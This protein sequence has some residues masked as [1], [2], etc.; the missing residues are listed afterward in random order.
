MSRPRGPAPA[1]LVAVA[2]VPAAPADGTAS[3][4]RSVVRDAVV[5][6]VLDA[7]VHTSTPGRYTGAQVL[8]RLAGRPRTVLD[9]A[10]PLVR[11]D[12]ERV[13]AE[14]PASVLDVSAPAGPAP[15]P[16]PSIAVVVPTVVGRVDELD[17]LLTSLAVL[18][19]PDVDVVLVDNRTTR[20]LHDPLPDLLARHPGVRCVRE[21]RPGIS[22]ARNAGA[23]AT[24]A[25]VVA[26][27][28]DD[29]AVDPGWLSALADRF[30]RFPDELAVTGLVVP[31]ELETTAQLQYEAH[32]GGFGGTRTFEA[33]RISGSNRRG[34]AV[35]R[36]DDDRPPH[37]LPVYGVGAYG[38]GANMAFRRRELLARGG[39]DTSLGTGT[40]AC[41]GE[42]LAALVDVLWSGG[43]IGY[44]PAALVHHT[45]RR[46]A[47][48][49]ERQ[50][51][52][53]GIGFTAM[54]CALVVR[55]HRHAT[56][57][58]ALVPAATVRLAVRTVNRLRRLDPAGVATARGAVLS[59]PSTVP[60]PAARFAALEL[61]GF[62]VGP[63]AYARSRRRTARLSRT[64][65]TAA[66][67]G[68]VLPTG[69]PS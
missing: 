23:A 58:A 5:D 29:V 17:R 47:A 63:A 15:G 40:P 43:A 32:Y 4:D 2:E 13:L 39:F 19:H 59:A 11:A 49:L 35:V 57:L 65:A 38:A 64:A 60:V 68:A 37:I 50:L 36:Y 48:G 1:L 26:F 31:A 30:A 14:L 34:L 33:V 12:V 9:V 45:H 54:L 53:N 16:R 44:E 22:A 67:R 7:L 56:A 61:S 27:T 52:G 24:D 62:P 18:D 3:F 55:D 28:D 66:S 10:L 8:L 51:H 6:G 42:D 25:D 21:P 41:G 20:T 46:D 69:R